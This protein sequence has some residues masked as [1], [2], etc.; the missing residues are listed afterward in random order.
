MHENISND[1]F[2]YNLGR[3]EDGEIDWYSVNNSYHSNGEKPSIVALDDGV[4]L[5]V[6]I[7][8]TTDRLTYN[9]DEYKDGRLTAIS[10]VSSNPHEEMAVNRSVTVMDDGGILISQES[11][12]GELYYVVGTYNGGRT[13]E[14]FDRSWTKYADG[15]NPS[16]T[17]LDDGQLVNVYEDQTSNNIYYQLGEFEEGVINWSDKPIHYSV[18]ENPSVTV[19]DNGHIAAVR[20]EDGL[21][22]YDV[23]EYTDGKIDWNIEIPIEIPELK[24]L[25]IDEVD[26]DNNYAWGEDSAIT[27][28]QN[29]LVLAVKDRLGDL[30]FQ[31]GE[32][33]DGKMYWTRPVDF[34]KGHNPSLTTSWDG[35][36]IVTYHQTGFP[37]H[38]LYYQTVRVPN[39]GEISA[40]F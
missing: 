30:G 18:G 40:L 28:L 27:V 4:V 37:Q 29:G 19:L 38:R 39:V 11:A 23:G 33:L 34:E 24:Y 20:E 35:T 36:V 17:V 13:L 25:N 5:T 32:Y 12:S 1:Y 31:L 8:D 21:L 22:Y 16:L 9:L 6:Y 15:N 14:W 2:T 26:P 10:S 3:Y 7:S